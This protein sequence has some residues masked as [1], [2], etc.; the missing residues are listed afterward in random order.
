MSTTR[1]QVTRT[2][3]LDAANALLLERGYHGVGLASVASVAGVSRQTVYDQFGSKP[4]LLRAMVA[5]SEEVAG[6]PQLLERV[7]SET[8]GVAM[9]R[10]F[11]DAVVAV[12]PQVYPFSRLVYAARLDDPVAAELWEWRLRSRHAGMRAVMERLASEGRLRAGVS[13]DEATDVA[14]AVASPHH[15]EYLVIAQG[16]DM[17]RYRAHLEQTIASRLLSHDWDGD[18]GDGP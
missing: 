16:W 12:E 3:I 9:L 6:L 13:V 8:R 1:S 4:G 17:L 11:L 2:R 15:Y 18:A 5:R 14:W 10:T 7:R